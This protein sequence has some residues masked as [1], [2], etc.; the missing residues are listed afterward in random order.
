MNSRTIRIT[1]PCEFGEPGDL[2]CP[3]PWDIAHLLVETRGVAEYVEQSTSPPPQIAEFQRR[4]R[5]QATSSQVT[6]DK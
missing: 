2:L 4:K 5:R 6:S 3:E 1:E